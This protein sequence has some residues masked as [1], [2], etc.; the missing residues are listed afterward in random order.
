MKKSFVSA[1]IKKSR[2][3]LEPGKPRWKGSVNL[4]WEGPVFLLLLLGLSGRSTSGTS[5]GSISSLFFEQTNMNNSK[6]WLNMKSVRMIEKN[7]V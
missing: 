3:Y 6:K 2:N 5:D 1:V 7:Q 4:C